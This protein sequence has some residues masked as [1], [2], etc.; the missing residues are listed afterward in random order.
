MRFVT[1]LVFRPSSRAGDG[2]LGPSR[3][4]LQLTTS[5]VLRTTYAMVRKKSCP[6]LELVLAEALSALFR[7]PFRT[8]PAVNVYAKICK[9]V[10]IRS[11]NR[12]DLPVPSK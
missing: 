2:R 10:I 1:A 9:K 11:T 8:V 12:R 6:I 4:Q 5:D 3:G 7:R